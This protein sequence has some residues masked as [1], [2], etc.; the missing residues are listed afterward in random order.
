MERLVIN[1][2]VSAVSEWSE[3]SLTRASRE[4]PGG[5]GS[6]AS[7]RFRKRFTIQAATRNLGTLLRKLIRVSTP[8]ELTEHWKRV[9]ARVE[10]WGDAF[11]AL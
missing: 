11:L 9:Q 7:T 1:C 2:S 10:A 5:A 8:R 4:R 3:A 6:E